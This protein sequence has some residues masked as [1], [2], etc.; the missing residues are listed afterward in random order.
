MIGP[1]GHVDPGPLVDPGEVPDWLRGLVEVAGELDARAFTRFAPPAGMRI[2]PAAVLVLFGDD[3][4]EAGPD[5]LLM[6][7][8]HHPNDPHS[9]Q[10]AFPGGGAEDGDGGPVGTALREAEEETGLE[11]SGVRPVALLPELFV[12]VSSFAV[13]PVLAHWD[14]PSRVHAADPRET[15][16]VARVPIAALVD[17]AN[18]FQVRREDA[19]WQGPAFTV[20]GMFVWGFTA[21][22][23]SVLLSLG[24]WER[25]WDTTDVRPIDVALRE[26]GQRLWTGFKE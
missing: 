17:P 18:R 22:L 16:S 26:H 19:G 20:N 24:G 15:S 4:V 10:I 23:L 1:G 12:P 5:V 3:R 13:T 11:P 25:E 2:K 14:H 9:G 8:A 7:R 21:G 6:E